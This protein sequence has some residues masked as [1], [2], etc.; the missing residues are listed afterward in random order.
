MK[1]PSSKSLRWNGPSLC[2]T[3][4]SLPFRFLLDITGI[5]PFSGS[6]RFPIGSLDRLFSSLTF[7]DYSSDPPHPAEPEIPAPLK[8]FN[9]INLRY[10]APKIPL[11]NSLL[12]R[13]SDNKLAFTAA[14]SVRENS[15]KL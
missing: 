2:F 14:R 12:M 9:V 10:P 13:G 3:I 8:Q 5:H 6:D 4:N 11:E 1:S 7:P 15:G